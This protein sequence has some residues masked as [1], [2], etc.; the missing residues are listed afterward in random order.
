MDKVNG[1]VVKAIVPSTNFAEI[2]GN[3]A[4][5]VSTNRLALG[6]NFG[7]TVRLLSDHPIKFTIQASFVVDTV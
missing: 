4:A 7:F 6:E 3:H 2:Y 5:V 1:Q